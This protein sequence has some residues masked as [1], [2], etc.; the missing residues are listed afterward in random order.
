MV[1][2]FPVAD[3]GLSPNE[4]ETARSPNGPLDDGA[5]LFHVALQDREELS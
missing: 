1:G 2:S 4:G 3:G 5:P